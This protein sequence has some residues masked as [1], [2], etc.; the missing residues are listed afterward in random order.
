MVEDRGQQGQ[1]EGVEAKGKLYRSAAMRPRRLYVLVRDVG[2]ME[3]EVGMVGRDVPL[4]PANATGH[5]FEP[6]V[7]ALVTDYAA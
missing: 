3:A 4:A 1:V 5:D 7:A 2:V 6:V